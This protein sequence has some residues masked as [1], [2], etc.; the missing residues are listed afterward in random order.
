MIVAAMPPYLC[1]NDDAVTSRLEIFSGDRSHIFSWCPRTH[2]VHFTVILPGALLNHKDLTS[3][4]SAVRP[5]QT[6]FKQPG[7]W[8]W[9]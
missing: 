1:Y 6:L 4:V 8:A 5:V 7:T 2:L 3:G 9:L